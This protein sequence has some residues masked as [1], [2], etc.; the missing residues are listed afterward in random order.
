MI[1][2]V[3]IQCS[4]TKILLNRMPQHLNY[5]THGLIQSF[6]VGYYAVEERWGGG[7]ITAIFRELLLWVKTGS[8]I[9]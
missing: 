6:L 8:N 5:K 1:L 4:M 9:R 3:S 7:W 2:R